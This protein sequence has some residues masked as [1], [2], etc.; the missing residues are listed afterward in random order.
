[1]DIALL[2][3]LFG[4][5]RRWHGPCTVIMNGNAALKTHGGDSIVSGGIKKYAPRT[6][7]GRVNADAVCL[8]DDCSAFLIVQQQKIRHDTGEENIRQILTV[9]NP[10]EVIA[11]EFADITPLAILGLQAPNIRSA[12]GLPNHHGVYSR[13]S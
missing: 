8:M 1:M 3:K 2:Q 4:K 13:P 12:P 9:A 6:V 7:S 10:S 5:D 11:V